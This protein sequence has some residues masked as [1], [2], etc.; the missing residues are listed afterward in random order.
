MTASKF[1]H[2]SKPRGLRYRLSIWA[3]ILIAVGAMLLLLLILG[4]VLAF[5]HNS[6]RG[7]VKIRKP[8]PER[9]RNDEQGNSRIQLISEIVQKK[10]VEFI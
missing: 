4:G 10:L 5:A 9:R 3:W 2:C 8:E 6:K 7:S 1:H